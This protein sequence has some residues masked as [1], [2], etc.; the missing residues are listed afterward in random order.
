VSINF[1]HKTAIWVGSEQS[2]YSAADTSSA[3]GLR[4]M[5]S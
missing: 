1:L 4:F 5:L 2:C 3:V